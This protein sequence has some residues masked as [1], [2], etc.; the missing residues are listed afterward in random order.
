MDTKV[1]STSVS[2]A[3]LTDGDDDDDMLRLSVIRSARVHPLSSLNEHKEKVCINYDEQMCFYLD[4]F[5]T[6]TEYTNEFEMLPLDIIV[7]IY[8]C[9]Q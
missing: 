9:E 6:C 2:T 3:A 4:E 7:S 5:K 8:R 1:D